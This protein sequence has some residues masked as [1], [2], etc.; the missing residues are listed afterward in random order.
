MSDEKLDLILTVVSDI[1]LKV[2]N[3]E[4]R[5]DG[6]EF[7][8]EGFKICVTDAMAVLQNRFN[9]LERQMV[10]IG[11]EIKSAIKLEIG[12]VGKQ[13]D[14][15]EEEILLNRTERVSD[16]RKI[17]DFETRLTRLENHVGIAI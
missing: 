10:A 4:T 9:A 7:E 16:R 5:F 11:V 13:I 3:L 2:D 12:T 6:L 17:K 14:R 8:F 1:K 15:S